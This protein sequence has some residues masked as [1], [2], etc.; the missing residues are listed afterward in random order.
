MSSSPCSV[1]DSVTSPRLRT[2]LQVLHEGTES[3]FRTVY[4][5]ISK[6]FAQTTRRLWERLQSGNADPEHWEQ[7]ARVGWTRQRLGAARRL[8]SPLAVEVPLF[9]A[10][11][12][13]AKLSGWT[14]WLFARI[15][16]KF[17]IGLS[18]VACV[19]L[20]LQF[21]VF[22]SELAAL[23]KRLG[24]LPV[25]VPFLLLCFTK[26]CHELGHAIACHRVGATPGKI[27]IF[28]FCGM[29][30][31]YCDVT[32]VW[33][34]ASRWRRAAVMLAGIYV[35]WIIATLSVIVWSVSDDPSMRLVCVNLIVLCGI[36]TL[37]F[38]GNPLMRFDGYHV[39]ADW[40]HSVNLRHE[41]AQCSRQWI[42]TRLVGRR[43][44]AMPGTARRR[45]G[46]LVYHVASTAYRLT[47]L[48]SIA[49]FVAWLFD[50]AGAGG[51]GTLVITL[52]LIVWMTRMATRWWAV[53]SGQSV[54]GQV[55]TPRRLIFAVSIL[56]LLLIVLLVP[57]P[58]YRYATGY[59]DS[60]SATAVYLP[61]SSVLKS[62]SVG[63]GDVVDGNTV[64][65]EVDSS[66]QRLEWI[67]ASSEVAVAQQ[68]LSGARNLAGNHQRQQEHWI[69]AQSLVKSAIAKR[70]S[71]EGSLSSTQVVAPHAGLVLPPLARWDRT[72]SWSADRTRVS[73]IGLSQGVGQRVA[74]ES[75]WCR[76]ARDGS[77]V[78]VLQIDA[79]D[80]DEIF[81]GVDVSLAVATRPGQVWHS[82]VESVSVSDEVAESSPWQQASYQVSCPL[83]NAESSEAEPLHVLADMGGECHAVFHLKSRSLLGHLKEAWLR[84]IH[85][86]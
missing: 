85:S 47:V 3:R 44:A 71:A 46:M 60:G 65:A 5:D 74:P 1:G 37:M 73:A 32:D 70:Q 75:G 13:A 25:A 86:S 20:L 9:A 59:L 83:L 67:R 8:P 2:D 24:Q 58:R 52:A 40:V 84:W 23:P 16:V 36:S 17:W 57:L 68:Q 69:R 49:G 28:F 12:I 38:N 19:L 76:V 30:C 63:F 66:E 64:L 33:R 56:G 35:E 50:A 34:Q 11:S 42:V 77:M 31:P 72:Q 41:A 26:I 14:S 29:P 39:L 21:Q 15:A 78:A 79:E 48:V 55:E 62:V 53:A 4:C 81:R 45:F 27:G 61:D 54:W 82:F 6:T 43:S 18:V 80:R 7:A 10:A 51:L 22:A